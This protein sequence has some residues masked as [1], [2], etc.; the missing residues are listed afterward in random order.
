M[1][2]NVVRQVDD[3]LERCDF[4]LA[5]A[6]PHPEDFPQA[7][8]LRE[9]SLSW[10]QQRQYHQHQKHADD[11]FSCVAIRQG[12]AELRWI[13]L[14]LE[15]RFKSLFLIHF[16]IFVVAFFLFFFFRHRLLDVF[17]QLD[18]SNESNESKCFDNLSDFLV[19]CIFNV[20][21][22]RQRI[23]TLRRH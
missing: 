13:S 3:L 20:Q 7:I 10:R 21:D 17:V 9:V 2:V 16:F 5:V 19:E 15:Q 11:N 18:Y 22:S 4:C 23:D 14:S 1:L 8:L 6:A 12:L